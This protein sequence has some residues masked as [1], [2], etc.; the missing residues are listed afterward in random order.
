MTDKKE[1]PATLSMN[2]PNKLSLTKT[3]ESGKVKQNFTHGRSKTVT[4]EVRKSRTF[5]RNDGGKMVE[6]AKAEEKQRD[7]ALENAERL[8]K[9]ETFQ[10]RDKKAIQN[11]TREVVT[12]D[13]DKRPQPSGEV[14]RPQP[15]S[16]GDEVVLPPA[17]KP[18]RAGKSDQVWVAPPAVAADDDNSRRGG[19]DKGGPGGAAKPASKL[20]LREEQYHRTGKITVA[21][22]LE[23]QEERM[24]S[25]ASLKRAREK[26]KRMELGDGVKEKVIREVTIPEV[27]T[28]QELSNRMAERV[29]DVI[30]ALMKLG[31]IASASQSIDADT[32]ELIAGEFGHKFRR[33]T[34]GDVE[35]VLQEQTDVEG[36]MQPRAPVVTIMGHVD[37]GK[38]SLLDALRKTNVVAGEAGGI[39]QHI[40]AYQVD[41]DG[42]KITFLDT[43]G[44]EAFTAMRSRGASVTDIVVLVVAADDGIMAQTEEAISHAKAAGVPIIVAVNKIDKQGA[45]VARVKTELMHH[46]L[47]AE[48]FGGDIQVVGV[49]AKTGEG[50]DTLKATILLQA[51][52]GELKANPER[53]A[54]G[55]VIEAQIDK[56]RGVVA[57]VL[58]QRGTLKVGDIVVAGGSWGKIRAMI[59]DKG[60]Q[61]KTA[62]PSQPVEV[63]GL[64]QAPMAG[65]TFDVVETEKTARDITEYRIK[66]S[67]DKN[68][69]VTAKSLDQL[70]ADA[71]AQ[72]QLKEL[73]LVVKGDVQGSVEAIIGSVSKFNSDEVSVR[74]LHSG[75]GAISESDI[76][77]ARSTGSIVFGFNVRATNPARE[78]AQKDGVDIRYYS[79][80]YNLIDDVKAALSGMLSPERR[81]NQI[82]YAEIR[83]V[84]TVTKAGKVAG[85]YVTEG[86]V[87][88]GAGVRLLR[89]NVVIHEGKLKTLKRFK[90]EVKDVKVGFECGMAF[91]NYDDIREGDIIECFEVEEIARTI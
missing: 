48:E 23:Y 71:T 36:D 33:V 88:R 17:E 11:A 61:T 47:V 59:D 32:A 77:L 44:H 3:V 13:D 50:L 45:D 70:F 57:T 19:K 86:Q 63:L 1:Q 53:K 54:S 39:T 18:A 24:R 85:C 37:H 25:L 52:V 81:E 89:D 2:R 16:R 42:Q 34:E 46:E 66:S 40:G 10:V 58:V 12:A 15:K 64:D 60:V 87:K 8:F 67:R 4:V 21:Q 55:V 49:S 75:V 83:Q 14:V 68:A 7:T 76:A 56:G 31:T 41:M 27:I 20:K 43:P 74:V 65:D 5:A 84:F 82:G 90:D 22:A 30:K 29:N 91:E 62:I 51:E 80:I 9:P 79:I 26:A 38:T 69:V 78:L 6:V 35:N 73:L 72:Q 28:V